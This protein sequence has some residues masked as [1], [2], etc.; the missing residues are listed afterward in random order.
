MAW[1]VKTNENTYTHVNERLHV[2]LLGSK[3]AL[4]FYFSGH[5]TDKNEKMAFY[6]FRLVF[7]TYAVRS[8]IVITSYVMLS[9]IG[10]PLLS[11]FTQV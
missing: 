2:W 3:F 1:T 11:K 6:W 10:Y 9:W 7:V 8:L 5:G 4:T